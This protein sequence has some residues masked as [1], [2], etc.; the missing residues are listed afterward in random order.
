VDQ[1]TRKGCNKFNKIEF[2]TAIKSIYEMTFKRASILAG[3]QEY[4]LVPYNPAIVLKKITEYQSS[5]T[6]LPSR[7]TTFS[8]V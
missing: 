7:P 5:L 6:K 1:A 8:E 2:L 3:F 4:R